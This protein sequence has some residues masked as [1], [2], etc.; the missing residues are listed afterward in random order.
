MTKTSIKTQTNT[1]GEDLQRA[2][3]DTFDQ[4]NERHDLTKKDNEKEKDNDKYKDHYK[5]RS[6]CLTCVS[7]YKH[8][9]SVRL[10]VLLYLAV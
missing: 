10:S 6:K 7:V 9:V 5:D 3:P 1:F 2:I 4:S 8:L